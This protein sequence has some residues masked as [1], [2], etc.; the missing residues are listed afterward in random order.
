M[1]G[2]NFDMKYGG[3]V[4]LERIGFVKI[5]GKSPG[6]TFMIISIILISFVGKSVLF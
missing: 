1:N 6:S 3:N 4:C 5:C 2:A